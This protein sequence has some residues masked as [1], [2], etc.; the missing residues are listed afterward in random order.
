M[1]NARLT[2]EPR[3]SNQLPVKQNLQK[4]FHDSFDGAAARE[5]AP[6]SSSTFTAALTKTTV[7]TGHENMCS[8]P[9]GTDA[10]T[11]PCSQAIAARQRFDLGEHLPT[12]VFEFIVEGL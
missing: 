12:S 3:L 2:S 6:P 9:G 1:V 7:P 8:G 10:T 4:H 11:N 5:T